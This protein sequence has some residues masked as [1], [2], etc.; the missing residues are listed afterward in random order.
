MVIFFK[1]HFF[2]R[3][4]DTLLIYERTSEQLQPEEQNATNNGMYIKNI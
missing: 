3:V 2:S 4:I 1:V